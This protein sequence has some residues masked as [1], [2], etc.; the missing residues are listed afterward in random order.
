MTYI[1]AQLRRLVE[2]RAGDRLFQT[3]LH[4]AFRGELLLQP[5]LTFSGLGHPKPEGLKKAS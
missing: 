4:R 5:L 3:I 1:P 2:E